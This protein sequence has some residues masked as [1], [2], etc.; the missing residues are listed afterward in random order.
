VDQDRGVDFDA[1]F[2]RA[3]SPELSVYED[4]F[5]IQLSKNKKKLSKNKKKRFKLI[6]IF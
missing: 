2:S 5:F 4:L 1:G 3:K 6:A